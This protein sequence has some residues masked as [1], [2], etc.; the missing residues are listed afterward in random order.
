MIIFVT[1]ILVGS[2]AI[3][4]HPA[5]APRY[6]YIESRDSKVQLKYIA[7]LFIIDHE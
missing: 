2:D 3:K 6:M 1:M 5:K 4:Y 7:V